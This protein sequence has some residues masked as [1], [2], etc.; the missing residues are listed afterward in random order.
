MPE[1]SQVHS[2]DPVWQHWPKPS[3]SVAEESSFTTQIVP[4]LH[5]QNLAKSGASIH[6]MSELAGLSLGT[7]E[8]V[9]QQ[10]TSH[11]M[12]HAVSQKDLFDVA[13]QVNNHLLHFPHGEDAPMPHI[14]TMIPLTLTIL[15]RS[16]EQR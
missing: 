10:S 4:S 11:L 12:R 5:P 8:Q 7:A 16:G 3:P 2:L 13:H 6:S 1:L 9:F 14:A 15:T